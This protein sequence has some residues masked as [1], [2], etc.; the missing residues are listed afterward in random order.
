[1]CETY[2]QI[3]LG[4]RPFYNKQ[5]TSSS[6][7]IAYTIL[8]H[9]DVEQFERFLMAIY[10]PNNV[11]CVHI[12]SKSSDSIKNGVKSIVDC[13]D[14]VFIATKLEYIVYAGFSRLRADLNCMTDLV[15]LENLV[16]KHENLMGKQI[17]EWE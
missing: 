6:I 10:H 8:L 4:N 9:N 7:S 5:Q 1:M 14:N 16:N 2:K 11:Y 12:D 13:F 15:N 3:R 17:I